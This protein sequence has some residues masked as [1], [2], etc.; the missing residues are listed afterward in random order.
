MTKLTKLKNIFKILNFL[1]FSKKNS[2][3]NILIKYPEI[4]FNNSSDDK[5]EILRGYFSDLPL[6]GQKIRKKL[7]SQIINEFKPNKLIETG[8]YLGNTLE[9]LL[10]FNI[11]T[12]SVEINEKYY[13]IAKSRFINQKNLNLI[14]DSSITF[15]SNLSNIEDDVFV[16]LDS[17]WYEDLPLEQELDILSKFQEII[18]L[19][20][21]F[22]VPQ[23]NDWN[24]DSYGNTNLTLE[25]VI[26]P[27]EFKIY[28]PSYSA[29]EDGGFMTGC[30]IIAK[31]DKAIKI[32]DKSMYLEKY[33]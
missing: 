25:N 13:L 16:Y 11:P 5:D 15:L 32:L 27:N 10:T 7:V 17:H 30:V 26:F 21:D 22:K 31:G 12:Y 23:S 2:V 1:L 28:F 24:Y 9:F 18:V 3:R 6:N 33:L 4:V 8:T 29:K 14:L 20:D 19:I